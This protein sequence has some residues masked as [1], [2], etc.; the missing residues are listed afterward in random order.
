MGL[1]V[2]GLDTEG[3][4]MVTST[5]ARLTGEYE[6]SLGSLLFFTLQKQRSAGAAA[7]AP[8]EQPPP[9]TSGD[10]GVGA[11]CASAAGP[12]SSTQPGALN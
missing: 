10:A 5:G 8:G 6:D 2:Q 1:H 12:S 7:A 9:Q 11:D 3:P 4:Q